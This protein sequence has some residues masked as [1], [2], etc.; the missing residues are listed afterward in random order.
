MQRATL[1]LY[2]GYP[3]VHPALAIVPAGL[4][5][6]C[7]CPVPLQP[8]LQRFQ[9]R[10]GLLQGLC[11]TQNATPWRLQNTQAACLLP[12]FRERHWKVSLWTLLL[13]RKFINFYFRH[14]SRIKVDWISSKQHPGTS[15]RFT[16]SCCSSVGEVRPS[17]ASQLCYFH[18]LLHV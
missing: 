3:V 11:K 5:L 10:P 1:Q 6:S 9:H 14:C 17:S 16:H 4:G 18:D 7:C 2:L 15:A 13:E 12:F 8:L